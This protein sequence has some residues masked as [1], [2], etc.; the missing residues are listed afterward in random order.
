M[1]PSP[2]IAFAYVNR[3][4]VTAIGS[5]FDI[6][7]TSL[8]RTSEIT[9]FSYVNAGTGQRDDKR[10]LTD[11]SI[12]IR[13]PPYSA[14]GAVDESH[15]PLLFRRDDYSDNSTLAVPRVAGRR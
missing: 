7:K 8:G 5:F 1:R 11:A 15:R 2:V 3:L 10:Q 14:E 13:Y 4:A 9:D 6:G 12:A